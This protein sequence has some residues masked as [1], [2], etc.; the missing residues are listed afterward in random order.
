MANILP[1]SRCSNPFSGFV[2]LTS[3]NTNYNLFSLVSTIDP[4]A[5][6]NV[7]QLLII[8]EGTNTISKGKSTMAALTDGDQIIPTDSRNYSNGY[9]NGVSMSNIW[10]RSD[11][12]AQKLWVEAIV[13]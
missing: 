5:A 6:V 9:S 13:T 7:A 12:A 3:A 1:T 11:G 4:N 10:V 2:T 8:N